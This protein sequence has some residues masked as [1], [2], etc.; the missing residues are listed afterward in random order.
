MRY[1][2][3]TNR[4]NRRLFNPSNR[5]DLREL[6]YL[7]ENGKWENGCP[8]YVEDPWEDVVSMCKHKFTTM[9]LSKL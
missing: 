3:L 1:N 5:K 6:K 8:F 2:T 7:L 9:Q 4:Q